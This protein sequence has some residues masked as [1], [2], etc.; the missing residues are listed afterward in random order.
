MRVECEIEET[1]LE[2]D[3]APVEGVMATCSRCD[4]VTESFG[5]S[6]SSVKRCLVLMRE[7]CPKNES[8]FYYSARD[9]D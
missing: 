6:D 3:Y 4:H 1:E 2:G 7:E 9:D 8:N 5:T